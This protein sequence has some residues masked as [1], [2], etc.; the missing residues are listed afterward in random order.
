MPSHRLSRQHLPVHAKDGVRPSKSVEHRGCDLQYS[1]PRNAATA[2]APSPV[3]T[4]PT[5]TVCALQEDCAA[6][7]G[8]HKRTHVHCASH[9]GRLSLAPQL[10][11]AGAVCGMVGARVRA[12]H[13]P[14]LRAVGT[15]SACHVAAVGDERHANLKYQDLSTPPRVCL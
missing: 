4:K 3:R 8:V 5:T 10:R 14:H 6:E 11:V 1:M 9:R 2:N 12:N 15:V 13:G 7:E